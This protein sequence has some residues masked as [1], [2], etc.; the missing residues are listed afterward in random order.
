LVP[1][2][3]ALLG[4]VVLTAFALFG[5]G[6][7]LSLFTGRQA[8]LGG[9]RMLG[10]GALAGAATYAIGTLLGVGLG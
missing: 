7:T 9:L 2:G 4:S 5:V 8:W 3:G 1:P 6:A 10:I